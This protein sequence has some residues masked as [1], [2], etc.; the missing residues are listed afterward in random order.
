MKKYMIFLLT[1]ILLIGLKTKGVNAETFYESDYLNYYIHAENGNTNKWFQERMYRETSDN[2][3]AYCIEPF[4]IFNASSEYNASGNID[5][6]TY[7]KLS[8]IATFG[9]GYNENGYNH[10]D[11]KWYTAT[12]MLI[13]KTL[14]PQ[15][16]F[17]FLDGPNGN[18]V[19]Y[20][21]NEMNE[22]KRIIEI[23]ETVPDL[24]GVD[25]GK[26]GDT[27][28]MHDLNNV[29]SYYES[30]D[31]KVEING[32]T[33]KY[34]NVEKGAHMVEIIK[35][36]PKTNI[37]SM[38]YE[39]ANGQNLFVGGDVPRQITAI[40]YRGYENTVKIVKFDRDTENGIPSG[41]GELKGAVLGLYRVDDKLL[42]EYT[43]KD[44]VLLELHNLLPGN[45]YIKEI[46]PGKGY[47]VNEEKFP[48][49]IN[50]D[51]D[52][53]GIRIHNKIIEREITIH[54]TYEDTL[55]GEEGIEFE[56]K[57]YKG[58][59]VNKIKTDKDGI[60]KAVLPYGKYT[61]SQL[62]TSKGYQKVNDFEI[63]V[64]ET[65]TDYEYNLIDEQIKKEI[66]IHK[67]YEDT[68]KPEEGIEFEIKDSE[69]KTVN[70]IKTDKDGIAK[71]I[72]PYG[73]YTV[74][75]LNS[76]EGY[77]KVEDFEIDVNENE[78]DYEYKLFDEKIPEVPKETPKKTPKEEVI[79]VPN[80]GIEESNAKYLF[81]L[82]TIP[83]LF[84]RKKCLSK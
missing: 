47:T 35:K 26:V 71:I 41:E 75:Q 1:L 62:N 33:I 68:L 38:F 79:E 25:F 54:K 16:T 2:L 13:W 58:E 65:N 64:N 22:I 53:I 19:N 50:D 31:P 30:S 49:E 61:V 28:E 5:Q 84:I 51:T 76:S 56:I 21:E 60:A 27:L 37:V 81:L 77:Q 29:L 63:N 10:T 45:Y 42:G 55:K 43:L 78:N 40:T 23:Y 24:R 36:R 72:L 52:L 74:S 32:N 9:Y 15:S 70:K 66:T 59:T 48:F 7:E 11:I 20:L 3:P 44:S 6:P 82:L 14:E 57:N 12:Q 17:Y 83:A 46:T 18:R 39:T 80:S 67:S 69:G 34:K 8:E 4:K 73:K